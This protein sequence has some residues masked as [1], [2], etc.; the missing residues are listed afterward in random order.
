MTFQPISTAG[1]RVSPPE[2]ATR[3]HSTELCRYTEAW[4]AFFAMASMMKSQ[5]SKAPSEPEKLPRVWNC[6]H[7]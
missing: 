7:G 4:N 3:R 2:T 5:R 6:P 1:I